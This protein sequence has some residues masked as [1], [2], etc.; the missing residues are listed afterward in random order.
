MRKVGLYF[1][2]FNPIHMG[3]L[4]LAQYMLNFTNIDEIRF[5]VSPQNPFKK[6]SDLIDAQHRLAMARLATADFERITVSDIELSL[7]VP[8]FTIDTLRALEKQES[9][10]EFCIIMGADNVVGLPKWKEAERLIANYEFFVYPR[11]KCD[12][13]P[14]DGARMT[15]VNAPKIEIS[16]TMLRQWIADGKSVQAFVPHAACE[17]ILSKEIYR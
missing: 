11:E 4:M 6:Q 17:Y 9:N 2:S 7:P 14:I 3:H 12:I 8:S 13:Q 5:V 16:S 15:I 1:G 10:V